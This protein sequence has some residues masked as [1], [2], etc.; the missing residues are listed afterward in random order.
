MTLVYLTIAWVLGILAGRACAPP[1][2]W[3]LAAAGAALA[4]LVTS[5][6]AHRHQQTA[7]ALCAFALGAARVAL[8]LALESGTPDLEHV[9]AGEVEILGWVCAEPEIRDTYT[10]ITLRAMSITESANSSP[11]S[12]KVLASIPHYPQVRY[13]DQVVLQGT[14]CTPPET[15]T[16]SYGEYLL[17]RGITCYVPFARATIVGQ[18]PR[19]GMIRQALEVKQRLRDVIE[20]ILP[21]PD[22][23]LLSGILLGLGH[24]LPDELEVA[25]RRVGLTHIIVISGFNISLV[26]QIVML[27]QHLIH[28]QM[29]L[30]V[31][32]V[33]VAA[34]ALF[35]GADPPVARAAYM[36][37]LYLIAPLVGRKSHSLTSLAFATLVMTATNPLVLWS[38]SFQL[39]LTSTLGLIVMEP[40][41]S[42]SLFEALEHRG[43][44]DGAFRSLA[45]IRDLVLVTLVAQ[46]MTLPVIWYHFAEVSV[47]SLLANILVLSI[48]PAIVVL[49]ATATVLGVINLGIGR[50]A[51]WLVWPFL[52][53]TIW[54]VQRLGSL[55][56]AAYPVPRLGAVGAFAIYV[57]LGALTL[58]VRHHAPSTDATAPEGTAP[59][60][61]P[62]EERLDWR[63]R[64]AIAGLAA[65][66]LGVVLVWVGVGSLP[67]GR[68]HIYFL[69]IGQ[70]DAIL[71]RSESGHTVLVDGGPDPLLLASRLGSIL[72]FWQR[73]IDVVVATHADQDHLAGLIPIVRHYDVSYTIASPVMGST[74][75]AQEWRSTIEQSEITTLTAV[76]GCVLSL[77]NDTTLEILHPRA[78]AI[79]DAAADGNRHSVVLRVTCGAFQALLTADIDET[80][81]SALVS[82]DIPLEATVLKAAHH[83]A[84]TST[85]SAFLQAVAPQVA[86]IS[87]GAENTFGHPHPQVLARLESAGCMILRTDQ[88]GTVEI[89]TDGETAWIHTAR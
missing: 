50:V 47:I 13:G 85:S 83:G 30:L 16:F 25:F 81:E 58:R 36:G 88:M 82:Q 65:L 55:P 40:T 22:A 77:D 15:D 42:A 8:P 1:L 73:D 14:P 52:R 75:L 48:Q 70:G 62:A 9:D 18:Q 5:L 49:G 10:Q 56:W 24:T 21:S 41:L 66:G 7:A 17:S 3:L 69:D 39:S 33:T 20:S 79:P 80:A 19:T 53:Y 61:T 89:I 12:G 35:V 37:L 54:V 46:A 34:Y 27:L 78:D 26:A 67:D 38:V 23:G 74:P 57:L 6:L 87:A 86:I 28:R 43:A 72:P 60:T 64:L 59:H 31:S 4:M 84:G 11:A 63:D 44:P 51:A 71:I 68:L 2:S 45:V 29:A 76:Q 32:I